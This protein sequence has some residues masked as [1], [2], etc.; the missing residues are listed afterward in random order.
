MRRLV[1][2][3]FVVGAGLL[4]VSPAGA[5]VRDN[6]PPPKAQAAAQACQAQGLKPGMD[7]FNQCMN[8]QLD[9]PPAPPSGG[10]PSGGPPSGGPPSGGPPSGGGNGGGG[11]A[12]PQSAID[13]CK[14]KGLTQ[15]TAAFSQC[16]DQ[17]LGHQSGPKPKSTPSPAQQ[18]VIDA[19]KAK[20]FDVGSDAY[21]QCIADM[22]SSGPAL[23]P[24]QRAAM[25]ACKA[26]G[27]APGTADFKQCI[28]S[29][30]SDPANNSSLTPKQL[31]AFD[32]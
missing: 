17:Q 26:K 20:G 1:L 5:G 3:M 21:K 19:C 27:I 30:L 11:T 4:L 16:L 9:G 2:V 24:A 25:D 31:A 28:T 29:T 10:P 6:A 7:A 14:A 13:A 15:G 18:A 8:K 23:T 22:T 32:A 12:V